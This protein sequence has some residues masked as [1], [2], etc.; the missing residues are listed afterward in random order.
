MFRCAFY[1]DPK[2]D[3]R[4]PSFRSYPITNIFGS[5]VKN[6]RNEYRETECVLYAGREVLENI[7][8]SGG[9][10]SSYDKVEIVELSGYE[11]F[12]SD[13]KSNK[14]DL[15]SYDMVF[16]WESSVSSL[17]LLENQKVLH[18]SP[19]YFS[20]LPYS[21]HIT[22]DFKGFFKD[23]WL[24]SFSDKK[25][26][27]SNREAYIDVCR[28]YFLN[29]SYFFE[30]EFDLSVPLYIKR[31]LK[32][33]SKVL[34][35]PLQV[36]DYFASNH[37]L[38]SSQ[39]DFLRK[40]LKTIP[41]TCGVL[42]TQ[43]KTSTLS[44]QVVTEA[45]YP[46][47]KSEF[48]NL[49]FDSRLDVIPNISQILLPHVHGVVTVS[50]SLG[51]QAKIAG[52]YLAT[53]GDTHLSSIA[54]ENLSD[55]GLSF[56][57]SPDDE[58]NSKFAAALLGTYIL[59]FAFID[60]NKISI[61]SL[62][63]CTGDS[64]KPFLRAEE[65]KEYYEERVLSLSTKQRSSLLNPDV[66]IN[67][68]EAIVNKIFSDVAKVISFDVF[69]TLI[70]RKTLTPNGVFFEVEKRALDEIGLTFK[71]AV[72]NTGLGD[73]PTCRRH[74][75]SL[76][77]ERVI[78]LSGR[79][80]CTFKDIEVQLGEILGNK[81]LASDLLA[82]ELQ[83]EHDFVEVR[84]I[85]RILHHAAKLSGNH[86]VYMS[87]MYHSS[88]TI[89]S[90]LVSAG[91]DLQGKIYVSSEYG[92]HKG[93]GALF[94]CLLSELGVKPESVIHI[95]DN[96]FGDYKSPKQYGINSS[97]IHSRATLW[98][99]T[100]GSLYSASTPK[101]IDEELFFGLQAKFLYDL[102][103]PD[104]VAE[105]NGVKRF[106]LF[107]GA[108]SYLGYT[109][110][111][112]LTLK[113][114]FWIEGLFKRYN[115]ENVIFCAR[116]G[117]IFFEVMRK[118]LPEHAEKFK[119]LHV[120]RRTAN[121]ASLKDK[122]DIFRLCN[123]RFSDC[124]LEYLFNARF[125]I[126]VKDLIGAEAAGRV[127]SFQKDIDV[128][129][130]V[131]AKVSEF[132]LKKAQEVKSN[133]SGL[134]SDLGINDLSK[135]MIFDLGYGGSIQRSLEKA[136]NT[137]FLAGLYFATFKSAK[138]FMYARDNIHVFALTELDPAHC[139]VPFVQAVHI[140]ETL[141]SHY[142]GTTLDYMKRGEMI[143]PV[144]AIEKENTKKKDFISGLWNGVFDF[145]ND[146]KSIGIKDI[147]LDWK[148]LL[149]PFDS[150]AK[151]PHPV[152]L[153]I[154]DGCSFENNF[155]GEPEAPIISSSE[156]GRSWWKFGQK[157][158]D[159]YPVKNNLAGGLLYLDNEG[160]KK[161]YIDYLEKLVINKYR[162]RIR[163]LE[164]ELV[165]FVSDSV[166]IEKASDAE[167]SSEL[168]SPRF[169]DNPPPWFNELN[170]L[171]LNPDVSKSIEAGMF[172]SGYSHY[173]MY[174]FKEG[175]KF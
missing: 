5:F 170:Y 3:F 136:F 145:L 36:G 73:Y 56:T 27:L 124:S 54:D 115:A 32:E 61:S 93:S 158:Y 39:M 58:L 63:E 33:Y 52:K 51:L 134:L 111:G 126:S 173:I 13:L 86:I 100:Y 44:D 65:L 120:S 23:S 4:L 37:P 7:I 172:P 153:L 77:R 12:D 140:F 11:R 85:G 89:E 91:Y 71:E 46:S 108:A 21:Y 112:P 127:V 78:K 70:S 2:V 81:I 15:K 68:F 83:V 49:I 133:I 99:R 104:G 80:D 53:F 143:R 45:N 97:L 17:D 122:K 41:S 35:V 57:K 160:L 29:N 28:D 69:D 175:R 47:L 6:I 107:K 67:G 123:Q 152:D 164:S 138:S 76:V 117:Y 129:L 40:A 59:P 139:N 113:V 135:S 130:D 82:I 105:K 55:Q 142:E 26:F 168:K 103:F 132:I 25:S 154:F 84:E 161:V 131:A 121:L 42:V 66:S 118:L 88:E 106:P 18:L 151:N 119:Y 14:L 64:Y 74:A 148:R 50:S 102:P 174:G 22:L 30:R 1:V 125:S 19:G 34:M 114:C 101:N 75:E 110:V 48:P 137:N 24:A 95:G 9:T 60:N 149:S 38:G 146:F 163:E 87:D 98:K 20:R 159:E 166:A 171:K 156:K 162:K 150:L 157:I 144:L 72:L 92:F 169:P 141:F 62:L 128:V 167:L 79:Q 94:V 90:L 165:R 31:K 109:V 8:S 96:A 16:I 147:P 10:V 43:Y 116:D 155:S